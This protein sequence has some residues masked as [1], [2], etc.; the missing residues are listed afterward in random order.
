MAQL[1]GQLRANQ[2]ASAA[3]EAALKLLASQLAAA[4]LELNSTRQEVARAR[5]E[6]DAVN[7]RADEL[8]LELAANWRLQEA[9]SR[10]VWLSH[11]WCTARFALMAPKQTCSARYALPQKD[12]NHSCHPCLLSGPQRP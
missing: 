4:E 1:E 2:Q 12:R 11:M 6:V 9:S 8:E 3:S 7:R 5:S 10:S